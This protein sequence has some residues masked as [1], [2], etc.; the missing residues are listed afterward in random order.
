MNNINIKKCNSC[1]EEKDFNSFGKDSRNKNGTQNIC[2]KCDSARKKKPSKNKKNIQIID[3]YKKIYKKLEDVDNLENF[4]QMIKTISFLGASI[5]EQKTIVLDDFGEFSESIIISKFQNYCIF[6]KKIIP[7]EISTVS[8]NNKIMVK[9][10][11]FS[12][13]EI[14]ALEKFLKANKN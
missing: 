14:D 11:N 1:K 10:P 8:V 2:K 12:Q 4:E 3:E 7:P 9:V 13:L 5:I 6:V